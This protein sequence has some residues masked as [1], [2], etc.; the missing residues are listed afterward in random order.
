MTLKVGL[1]VGRE[2][3]FPPHFIDE[4]NRRNEGV[5]A[6]YVTLG[7]P[8]MDE[9]CEYAVIIDRISHEVPFYRTFLKCAAA[10]GATR[11][12]AGARHR[13]RAETRSRDMGLRRWADSTRIVR[14]PWRQSGVHPYDVLALGHDSGLDG[15]EVREPRRRVPEAF[16]GLEEQQAAR[17]E[18]A[19]DE[20]VERRH[21]QSVRRMMNSGISRGWG[22]WMCW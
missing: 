18:R 12:A 20:A 16:G 3:S 15:G 8:R 11:A 2:W 22:A 7:A 14:C 10:T 9:P 1:I 5:T 4:V 19:R 17:D 6:E 13:A 21:R